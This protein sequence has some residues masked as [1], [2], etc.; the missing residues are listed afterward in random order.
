MLRRNRTAYQKAY[1]KAHRDVMR[2]YF[3]AW[4]KE[5][6]ELVAFVSAK[7]RC[8]NKRDPAYH[9]YG[10][11]GIKFELESWKDII[12]AIGPRP[13][14]DHSLDRINNNEAYAKWNI[15][16]ATR[17]EQAANRRK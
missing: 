16:W 1:R 17:L 5:H 4:K 10:G 3:I 11:R 6:P 12:F 7:Q 13:S 14:K 2:P 9:R 8:T 15:R